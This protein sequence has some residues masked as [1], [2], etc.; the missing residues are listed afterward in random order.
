M[1]AVRPWCEYTWRKRAS[2]TPFTLPGDPCWYCPWSVG[3]PK[4]DWEDTGRTDA[5]QCVRA[6]C[7][8]TK[9]QFPPGAIVMRTKADFKTIQE[10]RVIGSG[11][12]EIN[13]IQDLGPGAMRFILR[14]GDTWRDNEPV[15]DASDRQRAEVHRLGGDLAHKVGETW[16]YGYSF[17]LSPGFKAFGSWNDIF[18]LKPLNVAS[19][20]KGKSGAPL[21][22]INLYGMQ[23]SNVLGKVTVNNTKDSNSRKE[24]KVR[25]FIVAPGQWMSLKLRVKIHPAQGFVQVSVNGDAFTGVQGQVKE[26]D[27]EQWGPKWGFYRKLYMPQMKNTSMHVDIKDVYRA[28][29]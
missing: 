26:P 19:K 18:Q 27:F 8:K 14:V 16:E 29:L 22:G 10:P 7:P 23:G 17:M 21:V 9:T 3:D 15:N 24:V 2:E 4:G 5:Y 20:W 13:N 6:S 25:D 12:I 11:G 1:Q 28:R